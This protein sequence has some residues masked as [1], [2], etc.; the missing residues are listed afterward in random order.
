MKDSVFV[1]EDRAVVA[2]L[3]EYKLP[4]KVLIKSDGTSLYMTQDLYLAKLKVDEFDVDRSIYVVGSEQDNH[5]RQLFKILEL[6]GYK[7]ASKCYHLSY[8]MVN[9][10]SGRMKSREGI[11]VDADELMEDTVNLALSEVKKRHPELSEKEALN[12]AEIIGLGALKFLML[13]YDNVT[14]FVFDPSEALSFE[15]ETGPYIQY[16][17]ARICSILDKHSGKASI[18]NFEVLHN[19]EEE[20][21]VMLLNKFQTVVETAGYKPHLIARYLLDLSQGFNEFYHACPILQADEDLMIAR[22]RL[23]MAV[24]QIIANG[25]SILRIEAPV[26]M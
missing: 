3:E 26:A 9:L 22:L 10:P 20:K 4:D 17:H 6:L 21:L 25:L 7:F 24:K 16:A 18:A 14:S 15:G 12:R 1:E 8:G 13:K 23:I 2:K 11:V 5:F 19:P